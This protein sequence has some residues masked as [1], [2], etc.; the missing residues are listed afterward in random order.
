MK[1]LRAAGA[2]LRNSFD[3]RDAVAAC[4]LVLLGYGGEMLHP[5]AGYAAAGA[6]TIAIAVL[7]V[8]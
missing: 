1:F 8:R 4:G 6:V 5:G 7:G 2:W 3:R